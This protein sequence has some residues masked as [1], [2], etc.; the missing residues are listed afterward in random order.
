VTA[1]AGSDHDELRTAVARYEQSIH[2]GGRPRPGN[3]LSAR[4]GRR[5]TRIAEEIERN[6]RGDFAVPTWA[7][8]VLLA[9]LIGGIALF[10]AVG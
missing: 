8:A 5:R 6:R 10:I 3:E 1:V 7:L 4:L 2:D 9:V